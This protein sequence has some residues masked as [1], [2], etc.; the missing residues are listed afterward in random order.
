MPGLDTPLTPLRFLERAI[1]VHP[2]RTAVI[3]G[4]VRVTYA[5]LGA[6]VRRFADALAQS[7]VGPGDRVMYLGVNSLPMLAAHYAVPVI[8]GVL[9]AVNTRLAPAEIGYIVEHSGARLVIG[10]ADLLSALGEDVLATLPRTISRGGASSVEGDDLDDFVATGRE[11]PLTW[12]VDDE[13]R[14]ISVNYT[15]GTTGR[16]KGVVYTHRGAYLNAMGEV[17]HQGLTHEPDGACYLWTLPMFHCNGWCTTWAL[18]AAAGTHVCLPAVRGP[19]MW[20]LIDDER[21]T[22]LAGAPTV[23]SVLAAAEEAHV[24]DRPVT[25]TTAGAPP[26]PTI[27]AR[28]HAL[29]I[30]VIHVYGL[31]E[32]YGPY[33][34][35][36]LKPAWTDE[37]PERVAALI[38]RQGVGML[39][40]DRLRVVRTDGD[41]D[42]LVDVEPD[43]VEMG[44]LVMRGNSVM[45][46]YY[47]N[48]EATAAAF[49]G[50]W[51]HSGD[52]GVVHPDGYVQLLDRSKDIII[53]GG[54]NISTIEVE[55]ALLSHPHVV[56]AAVVGMADETWGERPRA[57]V[58]TADGADVTGD[59]LHQHVRDRLAAFKAPRVFDFVDALPKTS[60]GK[61]R[62]DQLRASPR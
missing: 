10:D 17:L 2:E 15:S 18:T 5:Q 16:P 25:V 57:F 45:A 48:D 33:S 8:G 39:T 53:S 4:D 43:G 12:E 38:A 29:G 14:P 37:G 21:V 61:T 3:D 36:E 31:T 52:L 49:R 9:V 32:T 7:G 26:S 54:E 47:R 11:L 62:K 20:R 13:T 28:M 40:S 35:C 34:V 46:G 27:I 24:L 30:R 42:D 41:A 56:D 22:H 23:L 55:Q 51:F 58:V 59:D 1:E 44:E 60:T 19:E 6:Y 50:G